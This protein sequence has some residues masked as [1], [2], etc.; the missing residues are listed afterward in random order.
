MSEAKQMMEYIDIMQQPAGFSDSIIPSWRS[1]AMAVEHPQ[2]LHVR[3]L[4]AS[5]L[6][7]YARQASYLSHSVMGW[8]GGKMAA[9]VQPTDTDV[10]F[11]LKAEAE[12]AQG[13]LRRELQEQAIRE[14][15]EPC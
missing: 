2:S 6:S 3:D 9:V 10:A 15:V 14:G 5:Y 1:E 12:R 13:A 8:I 11:P 4:N 7:D